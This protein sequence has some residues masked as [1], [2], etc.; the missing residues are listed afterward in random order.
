MNNE[1]PSFEVLSKLAKED[2]KQ[3]DVILENQITA[4]IEGAPK[5]YQQRLRGLQF[6]IDMERKKAKTPMAACLKI[7]SMMQESFA[8]L[9][10]ALN[11][12]ASHQHEEPAIYKEVTEKPKAQRPSARVI[13]FPEPEF[14]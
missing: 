12:A 8:Q 5:K 7:S 13:P 6:T 3:L 2:P 9:S 11:N 14:A 10:T 1:L 4:L